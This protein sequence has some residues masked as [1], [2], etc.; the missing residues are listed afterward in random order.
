M[1]KNRQACPPLFKMMEQ[2][3]YNP[4][5]NPVPI[6]NQH[7]KEEI[8]PLVSISCLT[9]NHALFIREALEGFLMQETTF[10][11]EILIHDDASTD[12][13][14]EIIKEYKERFDNLIFPIYQS[15]N[16][17]SQGVRGMMARFNFSRA[18]GKY[19]ALC[20][21][22]DHW[23]DPLKLQKQAE[24]LETN[25]GYSACFTNAIMLNEM[26]NT[27][28]TYVTFLTEG[29]VPMKKIIETGGYIYP[30]ASL[31]VQT[32]VVR[33]DVLNDLLRDLA[34]DT[35]I[36]INAALHGKVY[37]IDQTTTIYR[38]WQG[39][40]YSRLSGDLQ[41]VSDWK[42]KRING[43]KKLQRTASHEW[44]KSARKK[45]SSESLF[46]L[47]HSK[48]MKRFLLLQN[49][50]GADWIT[51]ASFYARRWG[52]SLMAGLGVPVK[53]K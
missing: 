9:Y 25:K 22:D 5:A 6:A 32:E 14:V 18:R 26:N 31:M 27:S 40:L 12:D 7:W 33:K 8:Q 34:G 35:A 13:T 36:I 46:I 47:K 41:L 52:K 37:F 4:L 48:K 51:L 19:I 2:S 29:D 28:S 45:V 15:E 3:I 53:K 10:P 38:R 23:L 49:L 21:G 39:G 11:V 20:E 1:I 42:E 50:T 44:R 30:T 24:F 16:Q 43:Y 17:Y